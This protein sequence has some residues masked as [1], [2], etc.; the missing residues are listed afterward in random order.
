[1]MPTRGRRIILHKKNQFMMTDTFQEEENDRGRATDD[2]RV[3]STRGND[4]RENQL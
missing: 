4:R 2:D 3:F 1:M